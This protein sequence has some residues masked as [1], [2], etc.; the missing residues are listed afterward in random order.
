MRAWQGGARACL[1]SAYISSLALLSSFTWEQ[2]RMCSAA[3]A[4][5]ASASSWCGIVLAWCPAASSPLPPLPMLLSVSYEDVEDD[6]GQS[7]VAVC[8]LTV[9]LFEIS[10]VRDRFGASPSWFRVR[11]ETAAAS[12]SSEGDL[13]A[14]CVASDPLATFRPPSLQFK[15]G[16]DVYCHSR[17]LACVHLHSSDRRRRQCFF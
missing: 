6:T 12:L 14:H 2:D 3:I 13:G 16:L 4:N 8:G 17:L 15:G 9:A 5:C 11:R 1:K 10:R 7:M